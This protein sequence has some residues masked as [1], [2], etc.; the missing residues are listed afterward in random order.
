MIKPTSIYLGIFLLLAAAPA[1]RAQVSAPGQSEAVNEA[2]YRQANLIKLQRTLNDAKAAEGRADLYGAGRLYDQAWQLVETTGLPRTAPESQ[3]TISGLESVRMELAKRFE[4]TGNYREANKQVNDVLRV[5]PQNAEALEFKKKND[6]LL[7]ANFGRIPSEEAILRAPA[8]AAARATNNVRV[9]DGRML[10]E[11]GKLDD[12]EAM[13]KQA[14]K[15]DPQNQMAAYYLELNKEERYKQAA[16]TREIESRQSLVEVEKD[17]ATPVQRESLPKPN[18]YARA[19]MVNTSKGRQAIVAKLDLIRL[20]TVKFDNVPLANVISD[21]NDEAKKRD[22]TKR[23]LNFIINP[24][25]EVAA[26]TA[27]PT[28]NPTTGLPE[29]AAAP[30]E[31]VDVG[32]IAIRLMPPLT[33]VRLADVLNAIVK[34]AEKPIKY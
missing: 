8:I 16:Q 23:G 22:P 33:D 15:E 27:A 24:N 25:A 18:P 11:M 19:E 21:L 3:Q 12:A 6:E 4:H 30:A 13:L 32:G 34:V 28:I 5:D 14:L 9:Q 17:W 2:I 1:G 7:T 10:F 31:V 26:T 29:P 20:D